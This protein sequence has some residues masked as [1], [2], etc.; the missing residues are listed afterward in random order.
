MGGEFRDGASLAETLDGEVNVAMLVYKN[1]EAALQLFGGEPSAEAQK[2]LG[3][4]LPAL[5]TNGYKVRS[6]SSN[7]VLDVVVFKVVRDT[8]EKLPEDNLFNF[9]AEGNELTMT[10]YRD[11]AAR[12]AALGEN[13]KA[14]DYES[15]FDCIA[16]TLINNQLARTYYPPYPA[17]DAFPAYP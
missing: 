12:E 6:R 5:A 2:I 8:L 10:V 11:A 1:A 9:P 13:L 4:V 17:D 7:N 16:C 3:A 15:T 14:S